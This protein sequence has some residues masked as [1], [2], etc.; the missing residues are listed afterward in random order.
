MPYTAIPSE[1]VQAAISLLELADRQGGTISEKWELVEPKV[2]RFH[3]SRRGTGAAYISYVEP[4]TIRIPVQDPEADVP[5]GELTAGAL[6]GQQVGNAT[7]I[8]LFVHA[9]SVLLDSPFGLALV[10]SRLRQVITQ[11]DV[12]HFETIA[13][14][15]LGNGQVRPTRR[16]SP[17]LR[18]L[19]LTYAGLGVDD[20]IIRSATPKKREVAKPIEDRLLEFFKETK[21]RAARINER[22]TKTFNPE[23]SWCK[24][25][26]QWKKEST[27]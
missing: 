26:A 24:F 14:Q 16:Q 12:A 11:A 19:L 6:S 7:R 15:P 20:I 25:V 2:L 5:E 21:E 18:K 8:E 4:R 10:F 13:E 1:H 9:P 27:S 22:L 3:M 23:T 17:E